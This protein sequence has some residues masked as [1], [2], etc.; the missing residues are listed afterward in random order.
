MSHHSF[1]SWGRTQLI[2]GLRSQGSEQRWKR[3]MLRKFA[4][5]GLLRRLLLR[6]RIEREIQQELARIAPRK[7]LY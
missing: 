7:A 1:V 4:A 5:A 6:H 2:A 3:T